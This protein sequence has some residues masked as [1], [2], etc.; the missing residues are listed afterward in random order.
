MSKFKQNCYLCTNIIMFLPKTILNDKQ[1]D[2][3]YGYMQQVQTQA[4]IFDKLMFLETAVERMVSLYTI[5]LIIIQLNMIN[6][7]I[8]W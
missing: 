3:Y 4:Y 2:N 5:E 8:E 6:M 7:T 1:L